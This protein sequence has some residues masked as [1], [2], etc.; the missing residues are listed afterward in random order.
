MSTKLYLYY[1]LGAILYYI[2]K[3]KKLLLIIGAIVGCG[4]LAYLIYYGFLVAAG[5][6]VLGTFFN[7]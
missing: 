1:I 3:Y 2:R 6:L 4:I 7:R 5:L